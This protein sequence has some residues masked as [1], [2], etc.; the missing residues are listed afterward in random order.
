MV[1][2]FWHKQPASSQL[3]LKPLQRLRHSRYMN[4]RCNLKY[5]TLY[6]KSFSRHLRNPMEK[7]HTIWYTIVIHYLF[8]LNFLFLWIILNMSMYSLIFF[9]FF[10]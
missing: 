5:R 4:S 9:N 6:E 7:L 3:V 2:I 8:F 10:S 1:M